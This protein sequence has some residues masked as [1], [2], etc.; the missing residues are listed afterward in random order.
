VENPTHSLWFKELYLREEKSLYNLG[1]RYGFSSE[2]SMD[3]LHECFM[4]VWEKRSNLNQEVLKF[5]IYR[6][7]INLCLKKKRWQ[8]L[9]SFVSLDNKNEQ[10][11]FNTPEKKLLLQELK[12]IVDYKLNKIPEKY[13]KVLLLSYISELNNKEVA[14]TLNIPEGTVASRKNYALKLFNNMSQKE[15]R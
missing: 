5:Y 12:S 13:K 4:K 10:T 14:Q 6:S 3:I 7:M 15:E 2:E 9:K 1:I 11:E 8:K